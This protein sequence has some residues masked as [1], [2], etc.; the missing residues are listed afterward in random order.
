[1]H[2]GVFALCVLWLYMRHVQFDATGWLRHSLL[3]TRIKPLTVS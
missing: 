2:G 1:L 3:A